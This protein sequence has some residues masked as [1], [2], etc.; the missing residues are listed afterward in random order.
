MELLGLKMLLEK[1]SLKHSKSLEEQVFKPLSAL[2]IAL[3]QL[4]TLLHRLV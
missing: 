1:E 3:V 4:N 2:V